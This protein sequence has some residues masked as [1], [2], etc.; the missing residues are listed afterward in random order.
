MTP[1]PQSELHPLPEDGSASS[2]R[3]VNRSLRSTTNGVVTT[4][5]GTF[6]NVRRVA[7]KSRAPIGLV[8]ESIVPIASGESELAKLPQGHG[9]RTHTR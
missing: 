8:K 1:P 6:A 3:S 2:E 7:V 5:R 9:M 4:G